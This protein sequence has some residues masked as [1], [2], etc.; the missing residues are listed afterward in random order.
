MKEFEQADSY[1][2][3]V[4]QSRRAHLSFLAITM[5][6]LILLAVSYSMVATS[7]NIIFYFVLGMIL[8]CT[9]MCYKISIT[10]PTSPNREEWNGCQYYGGDWESYRCIWCG[11]WYPLT[12]TGETCSS[13]YHKKIKSQNWGLNNAPP[14]TYAR[15]S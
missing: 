2:A 3:R 14:I 8:F 13:R 4:K 6:V 7:F 5:P 12:N 1:I 15:I 11:N 9:W 10:L